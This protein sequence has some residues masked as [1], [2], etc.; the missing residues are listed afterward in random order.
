M[1]A[2]LRY[3]IGPWVLSISIFSSFK[4]E[5]AKEFGLNGERV[6]KTPIL[7]LP[8]SLGGRTVFWYLP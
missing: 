7:L 8:P 4:H 2:P 3:N 6:A 5:S 1:S